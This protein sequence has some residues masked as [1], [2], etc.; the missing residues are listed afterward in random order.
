MGVAKQEV[1]LS[2]TSLRRAGVYQGLA[3]LTMLR[4]IIPP[5]NAHLIP[6]QRNNDGH[7]LE[8]K[9]QS[10]WRGAQL[11]QSALLLE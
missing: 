9:A 1:V 5:T 11:L 10:D 7:Y 2:R 3:G 6:W 8:Y 4:T